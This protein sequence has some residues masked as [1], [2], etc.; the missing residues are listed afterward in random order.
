[1]EMASE[2]NSSCT[3]EP[4]AKKPNLDFTLGRPHWSHF[5]KHK[6]I[7]NVKRIYE[8]P[9]KKQ[10]KG[11]ERKTRRRLRKK[12]SSRKGDVKQCLH[13]SSSKSSETESPKATFNKCVYMKREKERQTLLFIVLKHKRAR[14]PSFLLHVHVLCFVASQQRERK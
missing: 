3:S 4:S 14:V 10:W 11:N 9:F 5:Q 1:M 6:E 13:K 8:A 2:L 7:T 12:E